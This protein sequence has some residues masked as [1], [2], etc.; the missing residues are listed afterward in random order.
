V[1]AVH[2][3]VLLEEVL[4]ALQPGPGGRLLDGTL[5]L[6]GHSH[7]WLSA[8]AAAGEVG[9]VV[10]TD[11]D[12]EALASARA[13]LAAEFPGRAYAHHGSYEEAE[14]AVRAAGLVDVDAALM[15]LG[16]SSLQLDSAARG[17]SFQA[18]GPLDMRMDPAATRTAGEIVNEAPEQELAD[19]L[20]RFGEEPQARRVAKAIVTERRRA[21]FR[22]TLRLAE[23][24]ARATGGRRGRLHPATRTF[25]ALRIAV[26]DEL[27][28][29]ERGLPAVARCLRAGGR[30]AVL[31]FHRL[32]D[33]AVKRFFRD[34]ER[35]GWCK[36][37]PD[38]TP[39]TAETRRNPRSR[40]AR[41]RAIETVA[42]PGGPREGAAD[43]AA[44]GGKTA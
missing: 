13:R 36:R 2:V 11:R 21:P 15:D 1:T 33:T 18:P 16:A 3:P 25:Q 6:G 40:S 28:R 19:L 41:L 20:T 10:G 34:G 23:C 39:G 29:L 5:G 35:A 12:P 44:T 43:G 38:R 37:L 4:D 27:G 7:A 9:F 32:E 17:F 22:D 14:A 31:T 24:V 8:T 26:N 30:M 42:A